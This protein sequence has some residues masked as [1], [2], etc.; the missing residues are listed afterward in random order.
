MRGDDTVHFGGP[1]SV[2][3]LGLGHLKLAPGTLSWHAGGKMAF[4]PRPLVRSTAKRPLSETNLYSPLP[5]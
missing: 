4:R 1:E 5:T 3:T 2:Q